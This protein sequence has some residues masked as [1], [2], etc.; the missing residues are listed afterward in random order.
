M[1]LRVLVLGG[2]TE[3]RELGERLA[4]DARFD[5]LVSFAG[6]TASLVRPAVAHRIGGFGGARGLADFLRRERFDAL[7]DATHPFAARM[8]FNAVQAAADTQTPLVRVERAAWTAA[9][10]DRWRS[11]DSMSA[12]ARALGSEPRRV[13]LSVGRQEVAAFAAAPQHDYLVRAIDPFDP[14]L[15]R[16]RVIAARGPFALDDELALLRREAIEVVVSKNSG[17]PATHAKIEAA[18]RLGLPVIMVERPQLPAAPTA[19]SVAAVVSW[20]HDA[21]LAPRGA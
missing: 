14:G 10:G 2:T 8:S 1:T 13:F 6:R 16:A 11:V 4:A 9:D 15:P 12:A 17:T 20:L 19:D 3:G 7:V 21:L 18:R 5:V